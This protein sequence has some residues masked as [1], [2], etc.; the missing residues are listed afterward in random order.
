MKYLY[1]IPKLAN[2]DFQL[3]ETSET[4]ETPYHP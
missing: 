4:S 3:T 1:I 2:I